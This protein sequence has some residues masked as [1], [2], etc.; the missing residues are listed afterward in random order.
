MK[1][2]PPTFRRRER[3][4]ATRA[5]LIQAA[6]KIFARDGFEAA[7]LEEIAAEAG[8][9]RGAFYANFDSKEDLF[10]ALLEHEISHR[11][12][13]AESLM[14]K[15]TDPEAKLQAFRKFFL[16]MG[17]DRR[18]S[19]LAVEFKL[20]AVRHPEVK[21]RLAAMNRRLV[22]SRVG[23]LQ[24]ITEASGRKLPA[25]ARA[26]GISLSAVTHALALEHMLDRN[27]MPE[28]DL[29]KILASYFDSLTGASPARVVN[30][31]NSG[32]RPI[33][34]AVSRQIRPAAAK[35]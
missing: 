20:F 11:I 30:S 7:K 2:A 28:E 26:V 13:N 5:R 25:S 14:A 35:P 3:A 23:I 10:L 33:S 31:R 27:L 15:F 8:Y 18:W 6:E 12:A 4:Q 22:G 9:T 1:A 34:K 16:T 21:A 29:K 24:D 32:N 17:Q 19:L